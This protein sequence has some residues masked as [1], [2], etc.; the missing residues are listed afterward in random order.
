MHV[1]TAPHRRKLI[2][3]TTAALACGTG[4]AAHA[5][6][7][8]AG[9]AGS[10]VGYDGCN[11]TYNQGHAGSY[12]GISQYQCAPSGTSRS[13]VSVNYSGTTDSTGLAKSLSQS[14]ASQSD[15]SSAYGLGTTQAD[16]KSGKIHLYATGTPTSSGMAQAELSDTLHFTVAGANA[17][18][19]TYIP[20]SF[21]FNGKFA[22]N[23]TQSIYTSAYLFWGTSFG[24]ASTY[25]FGY[26]GAGFYNPQNSP[27]FAFPETTPGR[28]GGWQSYNF[29]SY[30]PT[31]TRFT[32]VYALT[33]ASADIPIDF[34][35]GIQANGGVTLDYSNGGSISVGKVSGVSYTSDSGVFGTGG[36]ITPPV[37][38]PEPAN[39]ILFGLAVGAAGFAAG[40]RRGA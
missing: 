15:T 25:E 13:G 26:Y 24:N 14:S 23:G 37:S 12:N 3:A 18:T 33:G 7:Y 34:R 27:T 39:M 19:V 21:D 30:T 20:V 1:R 16:L 36:G 8:V 38:T 29:A 40:R 9:N 32:G 28:T 31:D 22:L 2:L 10:S 4:T 35:L 5:G 11:V 6:Y 17:S